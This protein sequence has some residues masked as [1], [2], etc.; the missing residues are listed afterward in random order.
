MDAHGCAY[1]DLARIAQVL[2]KEGVPLEALQASASL[3][4]W[5]MAGTSQLKATSSCL[6]LLLA[7]ECSTMRA[8][9]EVVERLG[10]WCS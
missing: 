7:E 2:S 1:W 9:R 10:R 5:Q 3:S 8:A 6:K 4:C